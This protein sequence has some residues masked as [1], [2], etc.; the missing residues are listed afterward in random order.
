MIA[1]GN[2]VAAWRARL[3]VD[4]I[5][6]LLSRGDVSL[7]Y[8]TRR[9]LLGDRHAASAVWKDPAPRRILARQRDDGAWTYPPSGARPLRTQRGYDELETYR[10]LSILVHKHAFDR[11]H[12]PIRRGAEFLLASQTD[13]GDLR[14]ILGTQLAPYYTA[15]ILD[16]LVT[17]GYQGDARVERAFAWLLDSRQEDGGWAIPLRTRGAN[18]TQE[19]LRRP[20]LR[21]DR[22]KPSSHM[23]TGIVL[24]A[25]AAHPRRRRD[26]APRQSATW[27]ASR[28][29]RP[30]S[31][32]DRRSA[33]YWLRVGFPFWFTDIVSALDTVGRLGLTTKDPHVEGAVARIRGLQRAN[34]LFGFKILRDKDP[35]AREFVTFAACRAI[36]RVGPDEHASSKRSGC[37]RSRTGQ[38][39]SRRP[40]AP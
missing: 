17:A 33:D 20:V 19:T 11:K 9:D 34:G 40:R 39:H 21:A 35:L 3:R 16:T 27:L 18:Y 23:V 31:Y 37:R 12:E 25:F 22:R 29:F 2:K 28:F 7:S 13:E 1:V 14:G 26:N 4:P 10:Q 30:D 36:R 8:L 15:A 24:R 32:P 38:P 6:V 5:P